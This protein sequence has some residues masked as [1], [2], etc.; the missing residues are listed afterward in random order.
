MNARGIAFG[1]LVLWLAAV[2]AHG[3]GDSIRGARAFGACAA[4]HSM[5][6]GRHMTGPSL[7]VVWGRQAGVA[8]G[9]ARFSPALK[10]SGIVWNEVTLDTWL[11]NPEKTVPAN[12]MQFP[13]IGDARV[14]ADLVAYLRAASAGEALPARGAAALPDLKKAPPSAVVSALRHCGDTFFVTNGE[15]QTLPFWEFNLRFK[16]DSRPSGPAPGRPV[17]VGQGMQGDRAQIVFARP[18]EISAFIREDCPK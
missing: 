13:G 18:G 8:R 5:E 10:N 2:P 6:P 17:V 12:Y 9:F 3:D 4:C 11:A 1:W 16:T 7:G 15:G 14:R